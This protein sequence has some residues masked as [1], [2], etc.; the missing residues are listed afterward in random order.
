M[1]EAEQFNRADRPRQFRLTSKGKQEL[2]ASFL[3]G[4]VISLVL[5]LTTYRSTT[6]RNTQIFIVLILVLIPI[7]TVASKFLDVRAMRKILEYGY[8][9][10]AKVADLSRH[11]LEIQFNHQNQ[12]VNTFVR[13]G[14][15]KVYEYEIGGEVVVVYD[16][17]SPK[18]AYL[19]SRILER[20]DFVSI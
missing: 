17:E 5:F 18:R 9:T 10:K 7:L 6:D 2:A 15:L 19:Y 14:F 11:G 13:E 4:P 12:T 3:L 16:P 20:Y 8:V 1:L